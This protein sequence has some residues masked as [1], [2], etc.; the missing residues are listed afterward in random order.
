MQATSAR[1]FWPTQL[2]VFYPLSFTHN[3]VHVLAAAVLLLVVSA[4]V[5]WRTWHG[6]RYMATGW[7]WYLGTLVPVIGLVQVGTQAM[8]DRY[9]YVPAVGVFVMATW[10]AADL[11]SPR[12]YGR[13]ALSAM[14]IGSLLICMVLTRTQLQYW[15]NTQTLFE[16]ALEVDPENYRAHRVLGTFF[17]ERGDPA[18]ALA[19]WE[20]ALRIPSRR[21][22][23]AQ[24]YGPGPARPETIAGSGRAPRVCSEREVRYGRR[25]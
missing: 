8:A 15:L 2:S 4:L 21:P 14:A 10:A 6:S 23:D 22:H 5:A 9:T 24:Q 18:K 7:L 17:W 13:V 11:L 3:A 20:E 25:P 16:H 12:R 19:H 1:S